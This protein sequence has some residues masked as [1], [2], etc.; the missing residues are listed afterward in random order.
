MRQ[1]TALE[2]EML[3]RGVFEKRRFLDLLRNFIVFEDDP[4]RGHEQDHRR[5]S[6]VL[7][8]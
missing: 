5:L 7:T 6:S 8:R 2:L 3:V 1:L 4:D